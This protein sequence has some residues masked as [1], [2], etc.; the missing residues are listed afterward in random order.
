MIPGII[1]LVD[2]SLAAYAKARFAG[3]KPTA[4][5]LTL[6]FVQYGLYVLALIAPSVGCTQNLTSS[7]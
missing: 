3:S 5:L 1:T 6:I 2:F 7:P 4:F